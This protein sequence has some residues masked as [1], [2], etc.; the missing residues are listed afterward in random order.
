LNAVHGRRVHYWVG[1]GLDARA[2]AA[3]GQLRETDLQRVW[4]C[5]GEARD[6]TVTRQRGWSS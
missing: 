6:S 2:R 1:F 5:D 3:I 4:D